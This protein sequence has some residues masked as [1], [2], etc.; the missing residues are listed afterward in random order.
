MEFQNLSLHHKLSSSVPIGLKNPPN[1]TP[2]VMTKP[3][4]H[5]HVLGLTSVLRIAFITYCFPWL[6]IE[7][8]QNARVRQFCL[9]LIVIRRYCWI[10]YHQCCRCCF[11]HMVI[12]VKYKTYLSDIPQKFQKKYF[13]F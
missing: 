2:A 8:F 11:L 10:Y 5:Q 3:L 4:L 1:F 6:H 9:R 7:R 13:I 12:K